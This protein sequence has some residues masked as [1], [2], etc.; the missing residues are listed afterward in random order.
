MLKQYAGLRNRRADM[1]DEL[2]RE[3]KRRVA[4]G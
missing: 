1:A 4:N 3:I 2:F